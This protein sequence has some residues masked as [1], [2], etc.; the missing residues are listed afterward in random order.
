MLGEV[1]ELLNRMAEESGAVRK[2]TYDRL[3]VIVYQDLRRRARLQLG[4]E[5]G[6]TLQPTALVHEAYERL[7]HVQMPFHNREHFLNVAATAMR[8]LIIEHARK[9]NAAKRGGGRGGDNIGAESAV[10]TLNQKPE[11]LIDI[12]RA[13][14]TLR[15]EQIQLTEL[16]FFAGFTVEETAVIMKLKPETVKKRWEVVRTLL[17]ERLGRRRGM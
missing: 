5:R 7:L 15:P 6:D 13:L 11:F 1:T 16:R 4:R 2:Q 3:V 9:A 10:G 12:D 17:F 8:R 14:Q